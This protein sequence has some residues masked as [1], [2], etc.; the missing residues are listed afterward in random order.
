MKKIIYIVVTGLLL[1]GC[2]NDILETQP[3]DR[4][5]E[6]SFWKSETNVAAAMIGCYTVL[7]N[8]GLFG[9]TATPLWEETA[10]PNAYNYDNSG[11][12]N[13]IAAGTQTATNSTIISARWNDAYRGI[14]RCNTLLARI[15]QVGMDETLKNRTKAEATFLR[16]LYYTMLEMYYGDVPLILD[17]PDPTTQANL[18]RT[19]RADVV[20]QILKDLDAAAAVLPVKYSQSSDLGRATRGAALALKARVLL[21]EASPLN[22]PSGDAARWKA[23]A[24]AAKA[25]MDLPGA[26]YALF[27]NY[28]NLFLPAND[29]SVESIFDVQYKS[30]EQGSSFDLIGR[31]YN[32]NAPVQ[33]LIDAY[34]MK[35]G[36][37]ISQSPLYNPAKPYEN[38][39]PRLYQTVVYPG[40]VFQGEAV[41]PSRF[42]VTGYGIKKYTIYDKEANPVNLQGGRSEINYMVIRYADVLLMYAEAQNEAGAT[43]DASVY[44]AINKVRVRA[45]M[46]TIAAGKTKEQLRD[47]IR[48]ERRIEFAGEGFYYNDIRRWKLAEQVLKGPITNYDN[49]PIM[50]RTFNAQRDYWWP[51]PQTQLDLNPAL[52]QNTGY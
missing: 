13:V 48:L 24:D 23:A 51:L 25:V 35:D 41:T 52:S 43:P 32:T 33:N 12:W 45:G 11:G 14:G 10:T 31:Q 6:E 36:L 2:G 5:T 8:E 37:P 49:K 1:S 20:A 9:G 34:L 26:G 3:Q 17:E 15:D 42:V 4:Y 21:F 19:P 40:D 30:P 29:N 50:T 7:R 16:A 38:R 47:L 28:R 18:P 46:P 22:N 44:D 27:P 39:D